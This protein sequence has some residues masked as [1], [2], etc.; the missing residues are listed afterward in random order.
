MYS[1]IGGNGQVYGPVDLK[2]LEQWIRQGRVL[3]TTI[4]IDPITGQTGPASSMPYSS[5]FFAPA[6]P[7]V[8]APTPASA[9][10]HTNIQV[11][12]PQGNFN[13]QVVVNNVGQNQPVMPTTGYKSKVAAGLLALFLGCFGIHQ[14]YLGKNGNGIAMLLITVL[15][16]GYGTVITGI[17]ALVDAIIILTGGAKDSNGLPLV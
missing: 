1:V 14:F 16:C 6:V 2:T 13:V 15:T 7:P 3:P 11:P 17:W 4:L 5:G 8:A 9:P 12:P 10:L